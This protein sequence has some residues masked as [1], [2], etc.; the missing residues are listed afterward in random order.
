LGHAVVSRHAACRG[1][2][3]FYAAYHAIQPYRHAMADAGPTLVLSPESELL[4]Y[5]NAGAPHGP[6]PPSKP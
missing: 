6:L 2:P 3:R 1:D 4:R 5:F